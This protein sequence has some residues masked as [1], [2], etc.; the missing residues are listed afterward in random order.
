VKYSAPEILKARYD[1][2]ILVYLYSEKTDVYSFSLMLWEI[3]SLK[4]LYKRPREYKGKKGLAEF[5]LEGNRPELQ[6]HWCQEIKDLLTSCWN[7]D[8]KIRPTFRSIIMKWN[9]LEIDILCPDPIGKEICKNLWNEDR[10]KTYNFQDFIKII[11][12]SCFDYEFLHNDP[13][14]LVYLNMLLCNN[15]YEDEVSIERFCGLLGWFGPLNKEDNCKEFFDRIKEAY[16]KKYFHGLISDSKTYNE[17][18]KKWSS[19]F[20][21][22]TYFVFRLSNSDVGEILLSFID[23]RGDIYHKKIINLD[24]KFWVEEIEQNYDNWTELL[25]ACKREWNLDAHL[26]RALLHP[27]FMD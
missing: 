11:S 27:Q 12:K 20:N 15:N 13:I 10:K 9:D 14:L 7:D 3:I 25:R 2:D 4:P 23:T 22:R 17:L 8:A 24:K 16:S 26:P 5:V 18:K 19:S 1:D 6:I 21:K